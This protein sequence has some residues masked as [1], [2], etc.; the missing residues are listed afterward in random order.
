MWAGEHLMSEPGE[1]LPHQHFLGIAGLLQNCT[2]HVQLAVCPGL[3]LHEWH[4]CVLMVKLSERRLHNISL[5]P[6]S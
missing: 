1:R 2:S 6:T 4:A 3:P 5:S